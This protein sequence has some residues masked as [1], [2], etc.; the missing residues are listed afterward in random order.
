MSEQVFE[1][2]KCGGR[3]IYFLKQ[4]ELKGIGGIYG[5]RQKLT[6]AAF[7]NV[8]DIEAEEM[9]TK[10]D[11]TLESVYEATARGNRNVARVFLIISAVAMC[12]A[13]LSL[14]VLYFEA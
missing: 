10:R 2:P 14:A 3:E 8:C 13:A 7:C 12:L 4:R 1:C 9:R 6:R 11:G 5:N